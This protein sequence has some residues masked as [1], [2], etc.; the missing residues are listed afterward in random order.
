MKTESKAEAKARRRAYYI[1]NQR[2]LIEK[3]R[4][5]REKN[6]EKVKAAWLTVREAKYSR[7]RELRTTIEGRAQVLYNAARQRAKRKGIPFDLSLDWIIAGLGGVCAATGIPFDLSSSIGNGSGKRS[8]WAPS[9]DQIS[10]SQGYTRGNTR[11]VVWAYNS[12]K[13]TWGDADVLKLALA[14]TRGV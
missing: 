5:Y 7:D 3:S 11:L 1:K 6:R 2:A 4:A 14:L 12:A 13:S 9:L 8:P 10:P